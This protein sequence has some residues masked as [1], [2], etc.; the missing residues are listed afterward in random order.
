MEQQFYIQDGELFPNIRISYKVNP[1]LMME[2][3]ENEMENQQILS[4]LA[5]YMLCR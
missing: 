1:L 3:E 4:A 5:K 2:M